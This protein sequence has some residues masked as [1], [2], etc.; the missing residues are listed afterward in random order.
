M[1]KLT[2]EILEE[3]LPSGS[4][5]NCH[6]E[7]EEKQGYYKC[8]NSFQVMNEVGMYIGWSDFSLIVPFKNPTDFRLH[9]HGKQS[10]ALN[11]YYQ[12]REYLEDT[13]YYTLDEME[14]F[15]ILLNGD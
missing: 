3:K 2:R 13:F 11:Q 6:W 10:Q 9:F 8:S 4:G 5:I 7:I 12:L 15:N 14:K 1:K